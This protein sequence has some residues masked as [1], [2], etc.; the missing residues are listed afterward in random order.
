[1]AMNLIEYFEKWWQVSELFFF[2]DGS[3]N[4]EWQ[5]ARGQILGAG[6]TI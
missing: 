2:G 3:A 5:S 6:P 1:M 4:D